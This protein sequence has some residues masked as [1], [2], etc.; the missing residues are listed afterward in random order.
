MN[1]KLSELQE[2]DEKIIKIAKSHGLDVGM[3]RCPKKE[4]SRSYWTSQPK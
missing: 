2:W 3:N 1:W 4:L